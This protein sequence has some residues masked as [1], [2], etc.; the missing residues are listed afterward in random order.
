MV[1]GAL[2]ANAH[3]YAGFPLAYAALLVAATLP[4][5]LLSVLTRQRQRQCDRE[6]CC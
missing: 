5:P 3:L 4:A 1:F 2:V 6:N